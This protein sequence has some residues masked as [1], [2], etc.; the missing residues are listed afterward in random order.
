[1]FGLGAEVVGAASLRH[2]ELLR[3][4]LPSRS[5]RSFLSDPRGGRAE[6]NARLTKASPAK[7]S[8][9]IV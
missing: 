6:A 2:E 8:M 5:W 3:S 1:M 7:G 9:T 4:R